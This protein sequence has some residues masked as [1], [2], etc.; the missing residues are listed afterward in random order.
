MYLVVVAE[1][2]PMHHWGLL[3]TKYKA[4]GSNNDVSTWKKMFA[5]EI[6]E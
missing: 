4:N 3:L 2:R 6:I 1:L 5:N